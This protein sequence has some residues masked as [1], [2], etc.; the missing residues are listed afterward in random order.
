MV[1]HEANRDN[2][3]L[4]GQLATPFFDSVRSLTADPGR[5]DER[6]KQGPRGVRGLSLLPI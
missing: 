1:S 5:A 2:Y 6:G 3:G 4:A